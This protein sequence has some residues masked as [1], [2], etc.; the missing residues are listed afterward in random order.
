MSRLFAL[1]SAEQPPRADAA[2]CSRRVSHLL[3][4]FAP[5]F[6]DDGRMGAFAGEL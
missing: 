5:T 6:L 3:I 1:P 2:A 4:H